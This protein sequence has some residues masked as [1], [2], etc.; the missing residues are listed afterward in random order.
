MDDKNNEGMKDRKIA[1]KQERMKDSNKEK[2][3]YTELKKRKMDK[4]Q[5]QGKDRN[6]SIKDI[7]TT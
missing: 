7:L 3:S 6:N 1:R 2:N 5:K 4:R